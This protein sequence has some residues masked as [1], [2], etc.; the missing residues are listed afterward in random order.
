MHDC[1]TEFQIHPINRYAIMIHKCRLRPEAYK[2]CLIRVVYIA[3]VLNRAGL[4]IPRGVYIFCAVFIY[5]AR[6]LLYP[7]GI[8]IV[9]VVFIISPA[10]FVN[11]PG[12][13]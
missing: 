1:I 9:P 4:Y 12:H 10:V 8:Y 6:C 13:F 3:R 7:L 11:T 2:L 5:I